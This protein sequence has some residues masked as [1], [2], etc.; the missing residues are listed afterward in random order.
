LKQTTTILKNFSSITL[1]EMNSI[2]FMTRVDTKYLFSVNLL[3]RLLHD[4]AKN[5]RVLEINR[6]RESNYKTI[7]FDTPDYRFF[8]Q[9]VTGKLNRYKI[10]LRTY[11]T[12]ALTFL[13]VKHKS[14]KGRTTKSRIRKDEGERY[15]DQKSKSFLSRKVLADIGIL[16]MVITSH[17]TRITLAN[18]EASERITIDYNLSYTNEAGNIIDLPFLAIAEIKR[19]RASVGSVFHLHLKKFGIRQTGFS[20]YCTGVALLNDVARKSNLKP[21]LLMLNKIKN[22]YSKHDIA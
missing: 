22:E 6:Q 15:D 16:R 13:E 5:Y 2:E 12:N 18:I 14:N 11:Q 3:P 8:N 21:K 19:E 20:K 1:D 9:H 17:F 4:V 7:Y 10:R